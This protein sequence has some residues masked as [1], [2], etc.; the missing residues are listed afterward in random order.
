MNT[1]DHSEEKWRAIAEKA[2]KE[3]DPKK[4]LEL[5]EQLLEASKPEPADHRPSKSAGSVFPQP[6]H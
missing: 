1:L 3:Q 4:L 2:S 5:V 6:R